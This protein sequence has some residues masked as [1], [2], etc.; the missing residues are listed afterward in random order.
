[1]LNDILWFFK[2]IQPFHYASWSSQ[3]RR[4]LCARTFFV[5]KIAYWL[6][7]NVPVS[8]TR[9]RRWCSKIFGK[10]LFTLPHW[11]LNATSIPDWKTPPT[12]ARR[13][14]RLVCRLVST[15]WPL[16]PSPSP[17]HHRTSQ[18]YAVEGHLSTFFY[19]YL[20]GNHSQ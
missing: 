14:R 4:N 13:H 2:E 5:V 7:I 12:R 6:V 18:S 16:F 20:L 11:C 3:H 1:M 17:L 15:V 10:L 9:T 19:V 8:S